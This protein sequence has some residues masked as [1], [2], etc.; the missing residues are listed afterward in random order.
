MRKYSISST[1][2]YKKDFKRLERSNADISKLNFVI[3]LLAAGDY[4]PA[5]YR[6]HELRGQ[7]R[8]TRECHIRGDW[9]LRYSKD[10]TILVL[11]LIST[12]DHRHVLGRE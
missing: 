10:D 11:L 5:H 7:L 8:G 1:K 9:L 12:G 2:K 3:N 6:D 4:L